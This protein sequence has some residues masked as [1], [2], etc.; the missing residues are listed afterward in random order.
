[1]STC[2][3]IDIVKPVGLAPSREGVRVNFYSDNFHPLL[4]KLIL[5]LLG[6]NNPFV[7][8]VVQIVRVVGT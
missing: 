8:R 4:D 2:L 5:R 7:K 1:M 3:G 6:G